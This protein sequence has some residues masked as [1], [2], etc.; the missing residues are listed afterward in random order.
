MLLESGREK[1][2][3]LKY[4]L[5]FVKLYHCAF[6]LF[7]A[8]HRRSIRWFL[9]QY[10]WNCRSCVIFT[11]G[12]KNPSDS[13]SS[14]YSIHAIKNN[15]MEVLAQRLKILINVIIKKSVILLLLVNSQIRFGKQCKIQHCVLWVY[16][17]TYNIQNFG[18]ISFYVLC[19]FQVVFWMDAFPLWSTAFGTGFSFILLFN[20][21]S[22][23][24]TQFICICFHGSFLCLCTVG[25][26]EWCSVAFWMSPHCTSLF[27]HS[28]LLSVTMWPI[29][30]GY[31]R[32]SPLD[33]CHLFHSDIL[34]FLSCECQV[35]TRDMVTLMSP[36]LVSLV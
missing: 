14:N 26:W 18:V 17:Y 30:E 25:I 13:F 8:N 5:V 33:S 2:I 29:Y 23:P 12:L 10:S 21:N 36:K 28:T 1:L 11:L 4:T 20:V 35:D 15:L 31:F 19:M 7:L 3:P 6:M 9:L 27:T 32:N 16:A 24:T 22:S 34:I